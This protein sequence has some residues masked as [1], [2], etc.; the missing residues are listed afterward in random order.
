MD[1]IRF[2]NINNEFIFFVQ[3]LKISK[4]VTRVNES[5]STASGKTVTSFV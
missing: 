2:V 5:P 3:E 4:M 1:M